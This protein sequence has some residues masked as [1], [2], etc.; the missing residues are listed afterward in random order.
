M[1][2]CCSSKRSVAVGVEDNVKSSPGEKSSVYITENTGTGA[3]A[4]NNHNGKAEG[5]HPQTVGAGASQAFTITPKYTSGVNTAPASTGVERTGPSPGPPALVFPSSTGYRTSDHTADDSRTQDTSSGLLG[6]DTDNIFT[7]IYG[8][9]HLRAS[10]YASSISNRKNYDREEETRFR[11]FGTPVVNT[12]SDNDGFDSDLDGGE[13]VEVTETNRPGSQDSVSLG[14]LTAPT[15][16]Q[17]AASSDPLCRN[18]GSSGFVTV[19][20]SLLLAASR[21]LQSTPS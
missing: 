21:L 6:G 14:S 19:T 17:Q 2:S 1:G 7:S 9:S 20:A 18:E 12:D 8:N 11:R 10:P 15:K 4:T 3:A 5:T 13:K 16:E